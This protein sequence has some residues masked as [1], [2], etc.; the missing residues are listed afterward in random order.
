MRDNKLMNKDAQKHVLPMMCKG[1]AF[2]TKVGGIKSKKSE[3]G[4]CDFMNNRIHTVW[5][6]DKPERDK[7]NASLVITHSSQIDA[8]VDGIEISSTNKRYISRSTWVHTDAGFFC[9]GFSSTQKH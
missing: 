6:G 5:E 7:M 9:A 4:L 1:C 8:N 3:Y 2:W